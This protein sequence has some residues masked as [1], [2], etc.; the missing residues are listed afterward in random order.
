MEL[1]SGWIMFDGC[2]V[3]TEEIDK[4]LDKDDMEDDGDE[5]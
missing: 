1:D 5:L 2:E 3:E 4:S